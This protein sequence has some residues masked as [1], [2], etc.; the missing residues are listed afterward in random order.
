MDWSVE[1]KYQELLALDEHPRI[2]AKRATDIGKSIMQTVC[3]FANEPGLGGGFILLGVCEPD[4][5]H[6]E[7]WIQ[8]VNQPDELLNKLQN[9]CRNQFEQPVHI[10]SKH[11][12]IYDKLVIAVYVAEL[13]A[14]AKPC[15]FS[16]KPD[17]TNKRKT[18]V[19][20]RGANG[21][22]ECTEKELEPLLQAK[23]GMSYDQTQLADAEWDDIDPNAIE[24]YRQ[25]RARVKPHAE[26]LQVSDEEMLR[27]LNLVRKEQ[28]IWKPNLAGILL[29]G[30]PLSLRRLL[31]S[32]RV[33]YVRINGTEW[34][35][36]PEQRFTTTLDL[37]D[38][39]IRMLPRLEATILDDMPRHFRLKKGQNQRSDEPLLPQKVV[40]EA[41]VNAVMHRDYQVNQPT[42]I[43]RYSNRLEIRNPGYSLKPEVELGEM[44][45]VL[46]NPFLAAVLYDLDFAETKGSGIRTMRKLLSAAGLAAPVFSSNRES[47]LFS[48]SYLL[49]QFMSEE[50]LLWLQKFQPLNLSH[51]EAKAMVLAR[52]I[53]A[54]DNAAMRA[55]SGLDRTYALTACSEI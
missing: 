43:V 55:V 53:G 2:E 5:E 31:P 32:V 27:A 24:L 47:N 18:S 42:L 7:Y 41:V 29:L 8:G 20:R 21:D 19:W 22:H 26:E 11:E 45:S 46:R 38:S 30:R 52:E 15:R 9:Y 14:A 3:A 44:G 37:R 54:I 1:D 25:L 28:N 13:D 10:Q 17:K 34:I 23:S 33:D 40:R 39:L 16:G 48:A 12:L 36:D 6:P 4:N 51:E 35:E 50:H 49:H